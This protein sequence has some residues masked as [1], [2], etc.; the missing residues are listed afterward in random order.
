MQLIIL[1]LTQLQMSYFTYVSIDDDLK[2]YMIDLYICDKY[3][4]IIYKFFCNL[5]KSIFMTIKLNSMYL[6]STLLVYEKT[7]VQYRI[8]CVS[9]FP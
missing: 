4:S 8:R 7:Q 3:S 6:L 1:I 9:I 5:Y 2:M